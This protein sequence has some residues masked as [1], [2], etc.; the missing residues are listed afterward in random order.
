MTTSV[1]AAVDHGCVAIIKRVI[2]ERDTYN[3]RWGHGPR[4]QD[5]K[6]LIAAG[7][8]DA[9]GKPNAKTPKSW[10]TASGRYSYLPV[11]CGENDVDENTIVKPTTS[12]ETV[13]A[14][15]GESLAAALKR[16]MKGN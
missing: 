1:I 11:L 4:A 16:K 3:S 12:E 9:K 8:L 7:K 6:A 5:K 15:E 2:M 14:P 13:D 10:I